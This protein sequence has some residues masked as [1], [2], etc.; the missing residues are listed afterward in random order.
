M[1]SSHDN[2]AS[3]VE[4]FLAAFNSGDSA[5]LDNAYEPDS[6]LIPRPGLPVTGPA[7][8]AANGHLLGLGLPMRADVR[9]SYVVDD[10]A[11]LIVDWSVGDLAGTATDVARRGADG[12]WRY[13]ID[14]PAGIA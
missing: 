12:V 8:A 14:N 10:I 11:L 13:V 1:T 6:V 5:S 3:L 7:R 9:H 4:M 2:P